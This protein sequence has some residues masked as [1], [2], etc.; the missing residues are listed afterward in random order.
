MEAI[1]EGIGASNGRGLVIKRENH[2][3]DSVFLLLLLSLFGEDGDELLS[4]IHRQFRVGS[5]LRL[6]WQINLWFLCRGLD[7]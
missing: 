6:E 3:S 4:N 7:P 1:D 5:G 2:G